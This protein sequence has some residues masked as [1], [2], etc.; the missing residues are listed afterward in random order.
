[1]DSSSFCNNQLH[2]IKPNEYET[3]CCNVYKKS[4][5]NQIETQNNHKN[6]LPFNGKN[7]KHNRKYTTNKQKIKEAK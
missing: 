5:A 4:S 1:M 6:I 3:S 2:Y 7:I